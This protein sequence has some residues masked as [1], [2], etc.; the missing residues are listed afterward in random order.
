MQSKKTEQPIT[1]PLPTL[2]S[3]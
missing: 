3:L 1:D 2:P